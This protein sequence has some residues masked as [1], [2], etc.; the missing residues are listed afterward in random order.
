M[1][2]WY[3]KPA[4]EWNEAL[5]LGNGRIGAMVYG[6]ITR[7]VIKLNEDTLWSGG[8]RNHDNPE[9]K[10]YLPR[11][12]E[13]LLGGQ[14]EAAH[15]MCKRMMGPNTESYLPVGTLSWSW[16]RMRFP[17]CCTWIFPPR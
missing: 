5:P 9:A 13:L 3:D 8:P 16:S 2:L 12:R 15:E 10:T 17:V 4:G 7:E 1:Q 6:G 11:V 14:Y